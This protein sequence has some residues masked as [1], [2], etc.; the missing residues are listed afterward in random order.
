M[1]VNAKMRPVETIP[2]MGGGWIRRMIYCKN[3]CKCHNV[4]PPS[5]TIKRRGKKPVLQNKQTKNK[6]K[7]P[8][9]EG[10]GAKLGLEGK[11]Q[12]FN[13]RMRKHGSKN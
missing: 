9:A 8:W 3:F 2:G 11:E 13:R 7:E 6:A 12:E 10:E 1:Y 5:T 4:H